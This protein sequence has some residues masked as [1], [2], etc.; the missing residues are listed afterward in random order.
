MQ[1]IDRGDQARK[2][3][4][5]LGHPVVDAD[6][7]WLEPGELFLDYVKELS[8]EKAAG[9]L[10][11]HFERIDGWYGATPGQ[12]M[13]LR[14]VRPGWWTEPTDTYDRA[15]A[16]LPA[17]MRRRLD[18]LGIDVGIIYPSLGMMLLAIRD[19]ELRG[20]AVRAFNTMTADQFRPHR[21]RLL[22][23]AIVPTQT[24]QEAVESLRFAVRE[25][26][27]R[28]ILI[29]SLIYRPLNATGELQSTAAHGATGANYFIDPL[30]ID[31]AYDYD[32]LWRACIELKV[33]VTAHN[34]G[35]GW[36]D[37]QSP[38]NYV[39]NHMGHFAAAN[40]AFC[41]A[42]VMGGVLR[43]FPELNVAFLEGG[44]AWAA[45][46]YSDLLSHWNTRNPKALAQYLSPARLDMAQ[47]RRFIDEHGDAR[48]RAVADRMI[49]NPGS[50]RLRKSA[51]E[52]LSR[53]SAAC[54]D[55]AASGI[56]HPSRLAG[57]F[58]R[59]FFGCEADDISVPWAFDRALATRLQPMFGSDIGHF[60]VPDMSGVLGEAYE[61]LEEGRLD[62]AQFREFTY[63]NVLKLHTRMN[64]DFF[65]GTIIEQAVKRDLASATIAAPQA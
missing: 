54:D 17:L 62:A 60:D 32:P 42:M 8:G 38:S 27:F 24:P 59:C 18:D 13:A 46:L 12:R 19:P 10:L 16:M 31:S 26:G 37:R 41:K 52:L 43:R 5:Q 21:D 36:P 64:P 23:V 2:V 53:D 15:T 44:I 34:G 30:G 58:E 1:V 11:E 25:L 50:V 63:L 48:V 28:A 61:L 33:A 22:P 35:Y 14:L 29:G 6:G 45:K 39:Y 7:H 20:T 57:L 55:F 9:K 4:Q 40:D 56:D 65:A 49:A 51:Q 47:L 3:R